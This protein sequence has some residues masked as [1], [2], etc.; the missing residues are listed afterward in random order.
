MPPA[1]E[2]PI[3]GGDEKVLEFSD[4]PADAEQIRASRVTAMSAAKGRLSTMT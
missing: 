1:P 3:P 2:L 4:A